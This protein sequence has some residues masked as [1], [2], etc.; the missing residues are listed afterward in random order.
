MT[1][2][3]NCFCGMSDGGKAFSLISSPVHC[4]RSSPFWGCA[5]VISDNHY[6]KVPHT[7]TRACTHTHTHTHTHTD[8][9]IYI[10][11]CMYLCVLLLIET[12]QHILE[13]QCDCLYFCFCFLVFRTPITNITATLK[14]NI[15]QFAY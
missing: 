11:I 1:M 2:V 14:I 13:S 15:N 4:E 12:Y 3:T 8:V 5:K 10:Y 9:Y 7:H 6:T